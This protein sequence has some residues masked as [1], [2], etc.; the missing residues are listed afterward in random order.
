MTKVVIFD[1]FGVLYERTRLNEQLLDFIEVIS[2]KYTIILLTSMSEQSL[3]QYLSTEKQKTFAA[4][5]AANNTKYSKADP[6]TYQAV[7]KEQ[8][9]MPEECL[10]IDDSAQ[11]IEAAGVSGMQTLLFLRFE[12]ALPKLQ[13]MLKIT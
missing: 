13:S 11:N 8:G 7:A 10:F 4:I 1:F 6:R 2:K 12:D 3:Q 5:Y 9:Y